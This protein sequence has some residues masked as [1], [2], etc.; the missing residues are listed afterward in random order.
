MA[1]GQRTLMIWALGTSNWTMGIR[2]SLKG[3]VIPDGVEDDK[4][5]VS[6]EA[7]RLLAG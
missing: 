6:G 3:S 5:A 7:G 4:A 1:V 2:V